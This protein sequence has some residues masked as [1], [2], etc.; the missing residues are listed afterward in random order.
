MVSR[1]QH[2]PKQ[3]AAIDRI[4]SAAKSGVSPGEQDV[5]VLVD[6]WDGV[7]EAEYLKTGIPLD[8][9]LQ[10]ASDQEL[11]EHLGINRASVTDAQRVKFI[12]EMIVDETDSDNELARAFL[13]ARIRSS[14]GEIAYMVFG[15]TGFLSVER[16]FFGVFADLKDFEKS[17]CS[18]RYFDPDDIRSVA[19]TT[20]LISDRDIL[21]LWSKD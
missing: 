8:S 19:D 21:A 7:D 15:Q 17:F 4:V 18:N 10:Y 2:D 3:Q 9:I 20:K 11:A 1:M 12:R 14:T 13:S 5:E 16:E 6:S